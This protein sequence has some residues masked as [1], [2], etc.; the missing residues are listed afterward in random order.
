MVNIN[1]ADEV[2]LKT[3]PLIGPAKARDI[4]EY[5]K[6]HGRFAQIQEIQKVTGIKIKTWDAIKTLITV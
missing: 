6:H 5:R 1:T 4:V 2:R 3:L